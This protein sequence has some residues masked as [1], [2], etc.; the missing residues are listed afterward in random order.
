MLL[1][2]ISELRNTS[3][4]AKGPTLSAEKVKQSET[5]LTEVEAFLANGGAITEV[6]RGLTAEGNLTAKD[7]NRINYDKSVEDGKNVKG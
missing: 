7:H 6:E 1:N 4:D 5:I 2:E 3:R